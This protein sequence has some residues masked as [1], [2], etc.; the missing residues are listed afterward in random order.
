KIAKS[1]FKEVLTSPE[2]VLTNASTALEK[3]MLD[4]AEMLARNGL[5]LSENPLYQL[6]VK[7]LLLDIA[8][9]NREAASIVKWSKD[10]Y[11]QTGN[12]KYVRLCKQFY[13]GDWSIFHK[14]LAKNISAA[15][16]IQQLEYLANLYGE[17]KC[18]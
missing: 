15:N 12:I 8:V 7:L 13:Q 5:E 1:Y 4:I 10:C 9:A 3:G 17:E 6:K 18:I 11:I 14:E 16:P 2:S